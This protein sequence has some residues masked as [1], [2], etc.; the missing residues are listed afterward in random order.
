MFSVTIWS[1]AY[2]GLPFTGPQEKENVIGFMN[3]SA[4]LIWNKG[5][6]SQE[7]Q[8]DVKISIWKKSCF[9]SYCIKSFSQIPCL[10]GKIH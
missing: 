2:V 8:G 9:F 1:A 3:G 4:G 5:E 7:K 6:K 10:P